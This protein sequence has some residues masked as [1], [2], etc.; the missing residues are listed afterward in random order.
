MT[1]IAGDEFSAVKAAIG[2]GAPRR[3]SAVSGTDTG[4]QEALG[5]DGERPGIGNVAEDQV[6]EDQCLL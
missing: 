2:P 1:I 6:A 4:G 3:K 5:P